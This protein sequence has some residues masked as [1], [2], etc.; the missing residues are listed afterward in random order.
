MKPPTPPR[1][2]RD[3]MEINDIE[4]CRPKKVKQDLIAT[5]ETMKIH[6]IEGTKAELRHKP[7]NR[8]PDFDNYNYSDI[9]KPNF[10]TMRSTNPMNPSYTIRAAF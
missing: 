1:F 6:D 8:S 9:T 7:R 3:H 2:V 4:G 10:T 5:R